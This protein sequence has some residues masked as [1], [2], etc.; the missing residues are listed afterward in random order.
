M[1]SLGGTSGGKLGSLDEETGR[2]GGPTARRVQWAVG[3]LPWLTGQSAE[4]REI[5][6]WRQGAGG[7]GR[8]HHRR[9]DSRCGS[10]V[11]PGDGECRQFGRGPVASC[12]AMSLKP[13]RIGRSKRRRCRTPNP[14]RYHIRHYKPAGG[15]SEILNCAQITT[16]APRLA[17]NPPSKVQIASPADAAIE[18]HRVSVDSPRRADAPEPPGASTQAQQPLAGRLCQL[19]FRG[20]PSGMCG[21]RHLIS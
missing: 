20:S 19:G 5:T 16:R 4:G 6:G 3:R 7:L 8:Y 9:R 21:P 2:G 12:Q 11:G 1:A 15:I 17:I 10:E 14:R 13:A 18:I